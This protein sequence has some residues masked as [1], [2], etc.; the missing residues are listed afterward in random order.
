MK[1]LECERELE[2]FTNKNGEFDTLTFVWKVEKSV[3][4][5]RF[6]VKSGAFPCRLSRKSDGE[7]KERKLKT[8][9]C[10]SAADIKKNENK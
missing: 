9:L 5:F 10:S 3:L 6:D 1:V 7:W 4:K 2:I 8:S